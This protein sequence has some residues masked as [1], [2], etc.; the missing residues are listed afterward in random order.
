MTDFVNEHPLLNE[1]RARRFTPGDDGGHFSTLTEDCLGDWSWKPYR[2]KALG[3]AF[4]AYRP[5][6]HLRYCTI[7]DSTY[8]AC[9]N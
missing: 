6:P 9:A 7:C 1:A 2:D 5:E 3:D 8:C 4:V